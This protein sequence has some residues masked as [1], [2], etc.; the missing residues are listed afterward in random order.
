[1]NK[2]FS[3]FLGEAAKAMAADLKFELEI[4]HADAKGAEKRKYG[5]DGKRRQRIGIVI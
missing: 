1:M 2:K 4:R 3:N 5:M